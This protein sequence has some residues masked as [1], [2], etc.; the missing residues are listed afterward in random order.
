MDIENEKK[1][2]Y[3]ADEDFSKESKMKEKK[4]DWRE[5]YGREDKI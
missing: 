4:E 5:K 1:E 3:R 2:D